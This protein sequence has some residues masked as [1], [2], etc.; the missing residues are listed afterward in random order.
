MTEK[1]NHLLKEQYVCTVCGYNMIGYF[2]EH[3]PFC[4]A[5][6][7]N[8][9]T[10][11]EISRNYRVVG[12]EVSDTVTMLRS[13]PPLG[14]EHAAY[15]IDG[16]GRIY[17]IDCPS[18]FDD[19]IGPVDEII[20]THHHFLG[21]GNLYRKHLGAALAIHWK[22]SSHDLCRGYEFDRLLDSDLSKKKII[23]AVHLDGHTPGFLVYFYNDMLFLCDYVFYNGESAKFNPYGP[24]KL[25]RLGGEK[26]KRLL[27]KH[28]FRLVCGFDYVAEFGTW[29]E[30]FVELFESRQV[31]PAAGK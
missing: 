13:Q 24:P 7:E 21:A 14:F 15:R 27:K 28:Q 12:T 4:G 2:P 18:T 3:C 23:R 6:R 5:G 19:S 16:G 26:L 30:K 9:L 1:K 11:Q 17:W 31:I 29:H 8:F 25:T 10:T 22:D 20:Y